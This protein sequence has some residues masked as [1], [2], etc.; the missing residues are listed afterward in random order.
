MRRRR[1][2]I[3]EEEKKKEKKRRRVRAGPRSRM[4]TQDSGQAPC[5]QL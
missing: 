1:E 3:E 4:Q 5:A 2:R